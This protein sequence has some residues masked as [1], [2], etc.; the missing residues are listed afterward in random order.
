[1]TILRSSPTDVPG[2][3]IQCIRKSRSWNVGSR[4]CPSSGNVIAP[5]A[6]S[7]P[8]VAYAGRGLRMMGASN[9]S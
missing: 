3:E 7:A 1:M 4:D 9:R 2:A 8:T 5:A 6:I